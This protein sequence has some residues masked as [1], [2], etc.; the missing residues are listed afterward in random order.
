MKIAFFASPEFALPSFNAINNSKHEIVVTVTRMDMPKGRKRKLTPTI[1]KEKSLELGIPVLTPERLNI[2]FIN[3]LDTYEPDCIVVVAYGRI[4]GPTL[5]KRYKDRVINLHPSLLPE[6]RGAS[7][8]Q[9][10]IHRGHKKTGITIMHL[11]SEL[12]AGDMIA[13]IEF[14]LNNDIYI[15]E[16]HD[17]LS[18]EGGKLL[19][20]TLDKLEQKEI[21]KIPQD[22]NKST[23][24]ELIKKEDGL[25]NWNNSAEDISRLIRAYH[26][27]PGSYTNLENKILKIHRAEIGGSSEENPGEIFK[28]DD[29]GI[30]VVCGKNSLIIK[31][32]QPATKKIMDFS[33][34][35][36]GK[37]L[38]TGTQL[39]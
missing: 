36:R 39:I 28:I 22:H 23:F 37:K 32:L 24:C 6:L 30:H 31:D 4:I 3:E 17:F 7:P 2:D 13:Q 33:T 5:L 18:I 25:I 26:T 19:V 8:I 34:F 11:C 14:P 12:D 21:N 10:A 35:L 20:D 9:S 15:E 1:V 38:K 16:L 29:E 27:W